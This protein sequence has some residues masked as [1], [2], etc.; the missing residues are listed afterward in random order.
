MPVLSQLSSM[1]FL[2]R[3]QWSLHDVQ[4]FQI[5]LSRSLCRC[6]SARHSSIWF[7]NVFPNLCYQLVIL[8]LGRLFDNQILN[9]CNVFHASLNA[10]YPVDPLSFNGLFL[11]WTP[12]HI[13]NGTII[14]ATGASAQNRKS[15]RTYRTQDVNQ[16]EKRSMLPRKQC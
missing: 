13:V 3:Y 9:E 12:C 4:E 14:K 5:S 10:L 15:R 8:D 11:S 16:S 2:G 7:W 1:R 6:L